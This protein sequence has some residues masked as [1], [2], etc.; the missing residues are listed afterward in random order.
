VATYVWG[1]SDFSSRVSGQ[2][3]RRAHFVSLPTDFR[4]WSFF[5]AW[6]FAC[7]TTVSLNERAIW[8]VLL[9]SQEARCTEPSN[10]D[11]LILSRGCSLTYL[12][13]CDWLGGVGLRAG[14]WN[15]P[16]PLVVKGTC[17][18]SM[19]GS[20]A[21]LRVLETHT[22]PRKRTTPR[23]PNMLAGRCWLTY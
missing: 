20:W 17:Q 1:R 2:D 15:S 4:A 3:A 10:H 14:L 5:C 18:G 19:T 23:Q 7:E 6:S 11:R 12:N 21:I 9:A 16:A 8:R 13:P 22:R